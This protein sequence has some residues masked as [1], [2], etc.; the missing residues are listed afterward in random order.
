MRGLIRAAAPEA[1]ETISYRMPTFDLNG[2]HLVFFAGFAK[3][4]GLYALPRA[5]DAFADELKSY[6]TGKGSIQFPLDRTLPADLITRMVKFR[7]R[8]LA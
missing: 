1:N 2:K 5:M 3:H 6:K 8:E 7:V 4:I